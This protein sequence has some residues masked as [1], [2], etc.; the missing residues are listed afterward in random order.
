MSARGAGQND[1]DHQVLND[2]VVSRTSAGCSR[3]VP[4]SEAERVSGFTY[5]PIDPMP[6]M[7]VLPPE[8]GNS[9]T[10][11][12]L[13]KRFPAS[14]VLEWLPDNTVRMSVESVDA[15]GKASY[16][17]VAIGNVGSVYRVTVDYINADTIPLSVWVRENTRL[18]QRSGAPKYEIRATK[19]DFEQPSALTATTQPTTENLNPIIQ[20]SIPVYVGIGLRITADVQVIGS[21]ATISG[22]GVLGAEAE[23]NRIRGALV[24]QTLGVNGRSITG[25]LPIPSELNQTTAQSALVAVGSIKALLFNDAE[26]G[27]VPRVVGMYVPFEAD[28]RT[29]NTL[30]SILAQRTISWTPAS[31][32]V[33][34]GT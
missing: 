29:I 28:R 5:V 33:T 6:V 16:G 19:G 25:A 34:V 1:Y 17:P 8:G 20:Y 26:T 24:V 2:P 32:K 15:S 9:P 30:I 12:P 11:K 10:T 31:L 18:D 14:Q 13:L 3:L 7:V 21:N 22:L 23:A 27:T 4:I